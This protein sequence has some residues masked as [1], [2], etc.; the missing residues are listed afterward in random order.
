MSQ[1]FKVLKSENAR[2]NPYTQSLDP[3]VIDEGP[4]LPKLEIYVYMAL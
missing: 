3:P 2:Y 1:Y 4:N